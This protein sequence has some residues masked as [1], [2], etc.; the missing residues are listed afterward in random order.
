MRSKIARASCSHRASEGLDKVAA[1]ERVDGV[2]D[3]GFVR[4]HL[5]RA[6]GERDGVFRRQGQRLVHAVGVQR[7]AAA[8]HR[9]QGLVRDADQVHLR[10]FVLER[11]A[12]GLGVAA[13]LPRRLVGRTVA[14]AHR[15]GPEHAGGAV[16]GHLFEQVIVRVEEERQARGEVVDGHA[17]GQALFDVVKAVGQRE[18]QLLRG[19]RAGLADVVAGDRHRVPLRHVPGAILDHVAH[20]PH[21]R[22]RREHELVLGVELLEDVILERA[23]ELLASRSRVPGRRPGRTP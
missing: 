5:L 17:A 6:Q 2:G 8:E 11:A 20:Q 1:A 7:L 22:L 23:A 12:G 18:R 13:E 15:V 10:L 9:G 16:L 14:V 21:A 3:S 19:R 4:E